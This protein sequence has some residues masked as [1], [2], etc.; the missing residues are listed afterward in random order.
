M[1]QEFPPL[2][3]PDVAECEQ[4]VAHHHLWSSLPEDE[5]AGLVS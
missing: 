3:Q 2:E 5:G 4:E 1:G